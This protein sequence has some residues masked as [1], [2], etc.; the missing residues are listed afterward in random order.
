[1]III[2][3]AKKGAHARSLRTAELIG[4]IDKCFTKFRYPKHSLLRC[5]RTSWWAFGSKMLLRWIQLVP[6]TD[7]Y[8]LPSYIRRWCWYPQ[9][10]MR[11]FLIRIYRSVDK[12]YRIRRDS[13]L[14]GKSK[15][16]NL[17]WG[18]QDHLEAPTSLVLDHRQQR[19]PDLP[20]L[21]IQIFEWN[22]SDKTIALLLSACGLC[23]HGDIR[24]G[25]SGLGGV[26][27][28]CWNVNAIA[29]SRKT[30]TRDQRKHLRKHRVIHQLLSW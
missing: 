22:S 18:L 6:S 10:I 14:A 13:Y 11:A 5:Y 9:H 25:L 4:R 3:W 27:I 19:S 30:A 2:C 21:A 17:D 12:L 20:S 1:M 23:F 24:N 28:M 29:E 8:F 15:P 26:S 16:L 7:Y